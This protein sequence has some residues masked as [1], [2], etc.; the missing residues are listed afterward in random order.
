MMSW[1]DS[2]P[3]HSVLRDALFRTTSNQGMWWSPWRSRCVHAPNR[4]CNSRHAAWT[5][6][7][8]RTTSNQGMFAKGHK[9]GEG[10]SGVGTR[11]GRRRTPATVQKEKSFAKVVTNL[12]TPATHDGP[13][14]ANCSH[15]HRRKG[16]SQTSGHQGCPQVCSDDWHR[17]EETSPLQVR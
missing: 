2:E 10:M 1:S 13:Y 11:R 6:V 12:T 14:E 16:T 5:G 3:K 9:I 17:Q 7:L 15:E 4:T 8:F